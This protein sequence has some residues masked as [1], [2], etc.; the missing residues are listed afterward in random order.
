MRIAERL[1]TGQGLATFLP[2]EVLTALDT[3]GKWAGLH[4]KNDSKK[5]AKNKTEWDRIGPLANTVKGNTVLLSDR[6]EVRVLSGVPRATLQA[7][8]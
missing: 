3:D 6:S 8:H 2:T 7:I 5:A 4:G 1:C